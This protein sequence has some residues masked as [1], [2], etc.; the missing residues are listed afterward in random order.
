[1]RRF[2]YRLQPVLDRARALEVDAT[3]ALRAAAGRLEAA[4]AQASKLVACPARGE[5]RDF[6]WLAR[7][8]SEAQA[9]LG[10]AV[11]QRDAARDRLTD[12]RRHREALALHRARAEAAFA[13]SLERAAEGELE[14]TNRALPRPGACDF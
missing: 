2:R 3:R 12:Q 9:R 11:T 7:V 13:V 10:S 14:A 8:A 1:M 6:D 5:A 4:L